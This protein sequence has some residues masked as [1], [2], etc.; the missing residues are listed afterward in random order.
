MKGGPYLWAGTRPE[1]QNSRS[2]SPNPQNRKSLGS[3]GRFLE[4]R[5]PLSTALPGRI[6]TLGFSRGGLH[7]RGRCRQIIGF[8]LR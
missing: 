8:T 3:L 2:G 5:K 4:A 6:L 1:V 7:G